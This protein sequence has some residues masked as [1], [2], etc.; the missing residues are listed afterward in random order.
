MNEINKNPA[1]IG[2]LNAYIEVNK[3]DGSIVR[4]FVDKQHRFGLTGPIYVRLMPKAT[5]SLL[6]A[7]ADTPSA[8]YILTIGNCSNP[9]ERLDVKLLSG[10]I[11]ELGCLHNARLIESDTTYRIEFYRSLTA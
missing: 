5:S 8:Y 3:E 11:K 4:S 7:D 6:R 1:A 2:P 9:G 10:L